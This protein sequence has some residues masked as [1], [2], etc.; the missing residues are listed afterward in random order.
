MAKNSSSGYVVG[1]GGSG[2]IKAPVYP[3]YAGSLKPNPL[4]EYKPNLPYTYQDVPK[5]AEE[6]ANDLTGEYAIGRNAIRDNAL[7]GYEALTAKGWRDTEQAGTAY[8]NFYQQ[9]VNQHGSRGNQIGA[10]GLGGSGVNEVFNAGAYANYMNQ[11]GEAYRA[12]KELEAENARKMTEAETQAAVDIANK[13]LDFLDNEEAKLIERLKLIEEQERFGYN[14]EVERAKWETEE[15]LRRIEAEKAA[16]EAEYRMYRDQIADEQWG[17][18]YELELR[19]MDLK[20]KAA[21]AAAKNAGKGGGGGGGGGTQ[22]P[23]VDVGENFY[24]F[25]QT[26]Q[27]L[28]KKNAEQ[29]NKFAGGLLQQG[30]ITMEEWKLME[31]LTNSKPG[32]NNSQGYNTHANY[33]DYAKEWGKQ[34]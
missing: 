13:R 21:K 5:L 34:K 26:Y 23:N 25:L 6:R 30:R 24:G 7:A 17:K 10:M 32:A 9:Q 3:G 22:T 12:A 28:F 27:M 31:Q 29:A 15:N 2:A 14:S 16:W 18:G 4:P 19:D 20:E 33:E 1:L 11:T 8:H